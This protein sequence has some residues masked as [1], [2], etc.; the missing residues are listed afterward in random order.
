M[1]KVVTLLLVIVAVCSS[2]SKDNDDL[3]LDSVTTKSTSTSAYNTGAAPTVQLTSFFFNEGI[4]KIQKVKIEETAPNTYYCTQQFTGG[5]LG[6]QNTSDRTLGTYNIQ[7]FNYWDTNPYAKQYAKHVYASPGTI[8]GRINSGGLG[9][10]TK[11]PYNWKLNQWYT[12]V[13]RAWRVGSEICVASFI[14]D[15][16]TKEWLHTA[17]LVRPAVNLDSYLGKNLN[18]YLQNWPSTNATDD[19]RHRRRVYFKDTWNLTMNNDWE[20]PYMTVINAIPNTTIHGKSY[21][22]NYDYAEKAYFIEHGGMSS[23]NSNFKDNR[24][25]FYSTPEYNNSNQI[26]PETTVGEITNITINKNT[27]NRYFSINWIVNPTKTP[28]FSTLIVVTDNAGRTIFT[29]NEIKPEKRTQTITE[30]LREGVRYNVKIIMTDIFN[31]VTYKNISFSINGNTLTDSNIC[32]NTWYRIKNKRNNNYIAIVNTNTSNL[33]Q[34]PNI[35]YN[36]TDYTKQWRFES[37]GYGY[38]L[39]INRASQKAITVPNAIFD[40]NT[41]LEQTAITKVDNQQWYANDLKNGTFRFECRILQFGAI[42]CPTN[43]INIG[44]RSNVDYN[45]YLTLDWELEPIM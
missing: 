14:Q 38:Y 42:Y 10:Q 45:D 27:N 43:S 9:V 39:I 30:I 31:Q 18:S 19:G 32:S 36:N 20:L 37:L 8:Q 40:N 17:T 16:Q 44:I 41:K 2:C 12:T 4:A 33:I 34:S 1:K 22:G 11:N 6:F 26:Q 3:G 24:I 29:N 25:T 28:Q 5:D 21:N 23:P 7:I 13:T 15:D 35:A